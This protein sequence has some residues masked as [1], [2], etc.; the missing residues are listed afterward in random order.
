MWLV[1]TSNSG[2]NN[3]FLPFGIDIPTLVFDGF[4]VVD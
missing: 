2:N 1:M 4:S 3:Q